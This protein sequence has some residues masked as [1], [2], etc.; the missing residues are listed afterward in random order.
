MSSKAKKRNTYRERD[1][2]LSPILISTTVDIV[3]KFIDIIVVIALFLCGT[4]ATYSLWDNYQVYNAEKIV[5]KDIEKFKPVIDEN[6]PDGMDK[7]MF[8]E[9]MKINSDVCG[10]VTINNTQIDYPIVRAE[11]NMKYLRTDLYGNYSV[12]GS[13]FMDSRCNKNFN[14]PVSLVY[15]HHMANRSMFGDIDLYKDADFFRNNQSG[16]LIT[17]DKNYPL[18]VLGFF[19]KPKNDDVLFNPERFT[20]DNFQSFLK[21]IET[22]ARYFNKNLIEEVKYAPS[23]PKILIL[24]TCSYEFSDARAVLVCLMHSSQ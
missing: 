16:T 22:D 12:A 6:K 19:L 9:L 11:N 4:Y 5:R 24:S 7:S 13:I 2:N 10:W 3:N 14:D 18:T 8:G 15:G 21:Y 17:K 1:K 20:Y 23:T